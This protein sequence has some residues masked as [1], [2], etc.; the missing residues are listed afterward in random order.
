MVQS[1]RAGRERGSW[2]FKGRKMNLLSTPLQ[3]ANFYRKRT[4]N[5]AWVSDAPR[6]PVARTLQLV[7]FKSPTSIHG[8]NNMRIMNWRFWKPQLKFESALESSKLHYSL[9]INQKQMEISEIIR[10]FPNSSRNRTILNKYKHFRFKEN[11]NTYHKTWHSIE[12]EWRTS[13][14]ESHFPPFANL[15]QKFFF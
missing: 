9:H 5:F 2:N 4:N 13:L 15:L 7:L 8:Q 11:E 6:F 10:Q 12:G 1:A 14:D 3:E